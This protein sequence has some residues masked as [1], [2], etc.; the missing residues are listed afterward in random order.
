MYG[1]TVTSFG[2]TVYVRPI[3][4]QRVPGFG[5]R[6][7]VPVSNK[8]KSTA[9]G[10]SL[11]GPPARTGRNGVLTYPRIALELSLNAITLLCPRSPVMVSLTILKRDL[12]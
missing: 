9:R 12:G 1:Q 11:D 10:S 7:Y 6:R 3:G 8:S 4:K 2:K 5:K